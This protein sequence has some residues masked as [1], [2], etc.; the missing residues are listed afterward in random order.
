[1][2]GSQGHREMELRLFS[3]ELLN[4]AQEIQGLGGAGG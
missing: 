3:M 4:F 1:M 2:L